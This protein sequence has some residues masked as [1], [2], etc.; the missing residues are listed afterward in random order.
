MSPLSGSRRALLTFTGLMMT[1]PTFAHAGET[2]RFTAELSAGVLADSDVGIADLDQTARDGD[3]A[4]LLGIR[5]DA[6]VKP[7]SGL[8]LRAGYELSDTRYQSFDAFNLQ[9]HRLSGE[10]EYAFGN[11][12]AGL[13]YNYVDARLAGERYLTFRQ[14]SPYVTHMFGDGLLVRGA[15]ARSDREFE[16]ETET[17][18]N[19]RS[20]E[21]LV[22]AFILLDGTRRYGVLGA[23]AGETGADDT[24]FSYDN[25]GLK[26]RYIQ[27]ADMLGRELT[28][29][30]GADFEQR[31]FSG[32]TPELGSRR[33]DELRGAA[34]SVAVPVR[35]PVSVDAGY[36]YRSRSSNLQ[37][38]DYDEHL[39]SVLLK[40]RF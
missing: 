4:S 38:A 18:R 37:A 30:L 6:E 20:D 5:L 11:T 10:G 17:G 25:A 2:A 29:R 36:E 26:A 8:T 24:A 21:I 40:V 16:T 19:S 1:A 7:A 9:T 33:K 13:L 15:Y 34:A 39:A 31:D 22:D 12:R 27:R 35:G 3:L 14:A 23:K 32:I 28:L